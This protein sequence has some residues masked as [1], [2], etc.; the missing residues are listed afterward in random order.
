MIEMHPRWRDRFDAVPMSAP[1]EPDDREPYVWHQWEAETDLGNENDRE[2]VEF[3]TI[4]T[5]DGEELAV[6]IHRLWG[7]ERDAPAK[8]RKEAVAQQIVNALTAQK[9][10][11]AR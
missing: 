1:A 4:A 8:A 5:G 10:V 2:G 6:I 11:S 7:D 3:L 9:G